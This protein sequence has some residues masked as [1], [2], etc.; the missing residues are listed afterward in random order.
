MAFQDFIKPELLLL[1]PVLYLVG[2]GLK[3]SALPDKRIPLALGA[4]GIAL[5]ALWV[6]ATC[7]CSG[8]REIAAASFTA[9]T[10]G[11]LAAGASVYADQI[12]KQSKKDE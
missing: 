2:V 4:C 10:Q 1:V 7:E 9:I 11:I 8:A 6:F 12:V 3:K 5:S